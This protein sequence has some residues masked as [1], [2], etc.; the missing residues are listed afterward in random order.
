MFCNHIKQF[1]PA[2]NINLHFYIDFDWCIFLVDTD[3]STI[4][5]LLKWHSGFGAYKMDGFMMRKES[6]FRKSEA[7]GDFTYED[8]F[9]VYF[10]W[11]DSVTVFT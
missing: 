10:A 5:I 7:G 8:G 9:E 2:F 6:A 4:I 3:Q 1:R 11:S